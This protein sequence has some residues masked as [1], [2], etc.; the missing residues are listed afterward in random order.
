MLRHD[1]HWLVIEGDA[2]MKKYSLH[3]LCLL[4][5]LML[6]GCA[7]RQAFD[8]GTRLYDNGQPEAGLSKL[9]EAV[10]LDPGRVEY[11]LA[12]VSRKISYINSQ[13]LQAEQL[14]G[15]GQLDK[16]RDAYLNVQHLDPDNI[17][18]RQ[19]LEQLAADREHTAM[20]EQ[21][22]SLLDKPDGLERAVDLLHTVQAADPGNVRARDMLQKARSLQPRATPRDVKLA[23][24]FRKPVT[25]DFRDAPL[26]A[27]FDMIG[28][29]SGLNFFFDRDVK[30]DLKTT[31]T[32]RNIPIENAIRVITTT[33]QLAIRPLDDNS[34]LVYPDTL[35]KQGDYQPVSVRTFHVAYADVKTLANTIKT[36]FGIKNVIED[37]RLS[38]IIVRDTPQIIRSVEKLVALEDQG[39]PEVLLEVEVLEIQRDKMTQAGITWPDTLTLS[40]LPSTSGGAITLNQLQHLNSNTVQAQLSNGVIN[41]HDENQD[42]NILANPR[43]RVKN[44]EKAK[45]LIGE[46]LPVFT[47]TSTSTGFVS[48]SVTYLDVGLKLEVQPT[49]SVDQDVSINVN[50]EVSTLINQVTS[51]GGTQAYQIGTRNATTVLRLR[52]G[53]TQL[54]AGLINDQES[55]SAS[56]LPL[57]RKLPLIGR[58]FGTPRDSKQRS[59]IV[60]SITPHVLRSV[61]RQDLFEA[62]FTAGTQSGSDRNPLRFD[63]LPEPQKPA[64]VTPAVAP[65]TKAAPDAE[66][67]P[68]PQAAAP[69]SLRW[70]GPSAVKA[71]EVFML[72]LDL[73]ARSGI[74][75]LPLVF[76]YD[77]AVLQAVS[78]QEGDIL[79]KAGVPSVF[80]S[81]IDPDQGRIQ[82]TLARQSAATG[83]LP[84]AGGNVLQIRFRALRAPSS[85]QVSLLTAAVQG[86]P[87]PTLP[88]N[89]AIT[90]QEH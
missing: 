35:Q 23:T 30:S 89:A 11:R 59:E 69:V 60:L 44:K 2:V 27:V 3:W 19:G 40:P 77:P 6:A 62:E 83:E 36:V 87:V 55:S 84:A 71:G 73:D 78:V 18:A 5:V 85:T 32:A 48:E 79:R 88:V 31:I 90:V 54:L 56:G 21:A 50:L 26:S 25:L 34:L 1:A 39:D 37:D 52:D 65:P 28:K 75:S 9:S 49:V 17:M 66:G 82:A 74:D 22:D 12:L 8:D 86:T 80:G 45:I 38:L 81:R 76:S 15:Q 58:L 63:F 4:M 20:L 68:A 70:N 43:I 72:N 51:K 57:L 47:T 29:S 16:A 41:L 10:R 53:E 61:K 33:N 7:A 13:L 67:A 64:A 24:A 46:K 42:S 14:R